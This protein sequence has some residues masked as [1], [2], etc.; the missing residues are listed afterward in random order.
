MNR[1]KVVL[2]PLL[3]AAGF[4]VGRPARDVRGVVLVDREL[5]LKSL[6]LAAGLL[7]A[8]SSALAQPLAPKVLV[9]TIPAASCPPSSTLIAWDRS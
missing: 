1:V 2:S 7:I 3:A 5:S 9:I 8:A 6:A 4:D